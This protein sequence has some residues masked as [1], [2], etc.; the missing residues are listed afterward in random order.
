MRSRMSRL[1]GV[2]VAIVWAAACAA[3]LQRAA[4]NTGELGVI[5]APTRVAL[6]ATRPTVGLAF[7]GGSARGI[8]HVGVIR[9]LEEHRIPIDVAAGTSMGGL[10]GGAFA[11]GMD[12]AELQVL[13]D[14]MNWDQLF[15]ASSFAYKNIRRKAD[16]RAFP[17]R[18]EFGLKGGIV[19]P[20]SLNSGEYV[21]LML[22]RIAAPYQELE[23]FDSLPTPFRTVAVDLVTARTVVL[24]RGS[25]A[26]AMRAT[27]SLPLIFPPVVMDGHVLVD[28]GAMNNVPADVVKDMGADVVIAVNVGDLS[29]RENLSYT[30]LG[31]AGSTLDAMMRAS[32]RT[33]LAKADIVLDVPLASYGSLDWRRANDLVAEGYRAAEAMRDR[34]LP[35]AV[36]EA[37]F[38]AWRQARRDR[39]QHEV[40]APA[41]VRVE[42]FG[43]NDTKRLEALLQRHVGAPLDLSGIEADLAELTGLDRYETI[44]WRTTR[45]E[46]GRAGLLVLGRPKA[47]APPFM[48]LGVNLENTTSRDFRITATARL[49]AFD[50]AGS[51]SEL[52]LDGTLGSDP[53]IG[54][55]W[56]RPLGRT[57]LF[58]APYAGIA[59]GTR[60]YVEDDTVTARYGLTTSRVGARVGVNLGAT[61]DLRLGTYVGRTTARIEVGASDLPEAAGRDAGADLT[62]R[63]DTQDSPVVPTGGV[64]T[65]V[66][67]LHVFDSPDISVESGTAE[68]SASFTQFTASAN[69]FRR[70][71]IA[72]RLFAF[73]G[74]GTSI[75]GDPTPISLFTLGSLFRLGAYSPGELRG[76]HV[77]SAGGGYLRQFGRLPDFLGGPV[78]AGA[79]LENGDAFDDWSKAGWRTNASAGIVMDTLIGP[80]VIAGS[81]GFDGRWRIY[82]GVGRVFR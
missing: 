69:A 78:Y 44:T 22:G 38:E 9:W 80:A 48:M 39:R 60:N 71:G 54:A 50:I 35:L 28:G 47:Y 55:E 14:T 41:F 65:Q 77:W 51:G 18:L 43:A 61:S 63:L 25:L 40:I 4:R 45:D 13:L 73:G 33:S 62:W 52:R 20:T 5:D 66:Q 53:G 27:M 72:G 10:I 76:E 74:V 7:G 42:G 34:L 29:D 30:M 68:P 17:S 57:P 79:W 31:L 64:L 81:S 67:L 12:A 56:Y 36:S 2:G 58:V 15:G 19:P 59:T 37:E 23:T 3:P 70:A 32:T 21:E 24:R 11:T 49:L 8:A 75:D 16:G 6:T 26:D 1:V 82:F 46:A